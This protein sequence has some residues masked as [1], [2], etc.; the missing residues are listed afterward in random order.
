[1]GLSIIMHADS[2]LE[3]LQT[4]ETVCAHVHSTSYKNVCAINALRNELC[5]QNTD[6]LNAVLPRLTKTLQNILQIY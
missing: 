4:L 3:V 5:S 6:L 1:M 2:S